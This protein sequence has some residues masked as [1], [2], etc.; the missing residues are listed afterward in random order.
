MQSFEISHFSLVPHVKG[1]NDC[2][3]PT[4]RQFKCPLVSA[5]QPAHLLVKSG[6]AIKVMGT[7]AVSCRLLGY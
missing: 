7:S 4:E 3:L 5:L 6:R 1:H 2:L